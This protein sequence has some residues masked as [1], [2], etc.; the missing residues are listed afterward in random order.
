MNSEMSTK[1]RTKLLNAVLFAIVLPIIGC[2]VNTD[3]ERISTLNSDEPEVEEAY[4]DLRSEVIKID[5]NCSIFCE[6]ELIN[7]EIV[8]EGDIILTEEQLE[9]LRR[10]GERPVLEGA[11]LSSLSTRWPDNLVFYTI[12]S[13]LINDRYR[14]YDAISH[15]ESNS[16]LRFAYVVDKDLVDNYIEFV[17][18]LGCSS[19]LGMVGDRQVITLGDH[20]TTGNTIHEI[21]HA[22]GI[23]H[24]QSR[25]DRDNYVNILWGNIRSGTEHNFDTYIDRGI[26][27]FDYGAFDFGSIMMY[28]SNAFSSNGLPTITRKDGSIFSAQRNGLSAMD[29]A[30]ANHMYSGSKG[31]VTSGKRSNLDYYSA[32]SNVSLE[33]NSTMDDVVAIAI[34]GSND[35][36]YVWYKDGTVTA[37]KNNDLDLFRSKYSYSLAPG[38]SPSDVVGIAIAG[39]NDHC[40]VWYKDGTVSSGN[41]R[42]L[43]RYKSSYSYTLASGKTP[44]DILDIGIAGS[45]DHCYVLYND[46][47]GSSGTSSD[48]DRY[49]SSYTYSLA[50]GKS[51]NEIVGLGIAGSNDRFYVWMK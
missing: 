45:N 27:G 43:D 13:F 6:Y 29:I 19:Y 2:Y 23:M 41:S 33:P 3:Y 25:S 18:G 22:I 48:L 40:Y 20:C 34:A 24:E 31:Q 28:P 36:C 1:K 47:T 7:G 51:I 46:G 8:V 4:P 37:G 32:L 9:Y 35:H 16:N 17:P 42:D 50:P 26:S 10:S 39:S 14:V 38:K 12:S 44:S 15:W 5:G 21:G 30:T 11:G 49:I